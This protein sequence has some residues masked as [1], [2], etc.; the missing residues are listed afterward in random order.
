QQPFVGTKITFVCDPG[1]QREWK[2]N[3][4]YDCVNNSGVLKW[5][6]NLKC[7]KKEGTGSTTSDQNRKLEQKQHNLTDICGPLPYIPNASLNNSIPV[8]QELPYR[9]KTSGPNMT[10]K[11]T[12]KAGN[13]NENKQAKENTSLSMDMKNVYNIMKSRMKTSD[14]HIFAISA[15]SILDPPALKRTPCIQSRCC[16][17]HACGC[18]FYT[19]CFSRCLGRLK[20]FRTAQHDSRSRRQPTTVR[21]PPPQACTGS[22]QNL[23]K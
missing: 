23:V 5:T 7:K 3:G 13:T 12:T 8:R 4:V 9:D 10:K 2:T 17:R 19:S 1:Y 22:T 15:K 21:N 6:G 18:C 14:I 11:Y 16:W 20:N